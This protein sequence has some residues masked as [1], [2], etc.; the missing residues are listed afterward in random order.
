MIE[1]NQINE[2]IPILC[3]WRF[4]PPAIFY[5]RDSDKTFLRRGLKKFL[6]FFKFLSKMSCRGGAFVLYS[7]IAEVHRGKTQ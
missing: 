2:T 3:G 1:K 6:N 4:A 5:V 7:E